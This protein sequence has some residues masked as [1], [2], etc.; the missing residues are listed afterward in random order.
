MLR[1]TVNEDAR[2]M[3]ML[4]EGKL[5]GDWVEELRAVWLRLQPALSEQRVVITL[6][7][8]C[9]FDAAGRH[10]LSEI[11]CAGGVL[12]GSGLLVRT[13][14]EEITRTPS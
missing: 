9:G 7:G 13:L 2:P 8:I 1:I 5:V 3:A 12:T 14:I 11:H 6:T 10:L 4:L